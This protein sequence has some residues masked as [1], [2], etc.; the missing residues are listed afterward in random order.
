MDEMN[1]AIKQFDEDS[2]VGAV[3]ITGSERAFA[4]GADIKEMADNSFSQ[5][6]KTHFLEAWNGIAKARKPT[7]AAVNG[8]A[9]SRIV[10]IGMQVWGVLFTR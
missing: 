2:S 1:V 9:V 5:N 6:I 7:I 10:Y 4:A 3:V 8:Y